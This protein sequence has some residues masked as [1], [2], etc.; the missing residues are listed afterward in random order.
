MVGLSSK[1]NSCQGASHS[2]I[3]NHR[4]TKQEADVV[5]ITNLFWTVKEKPLAMPVAHAMRMM[6]TAS[7]YV[8]WKE[9][10]LCFN[11]HVHVWCFISHETKKMKLKK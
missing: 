2:P 10:N 4:E 8:M 6:Y 11:R 1:V 9:Y 7:K 3:V 5:T